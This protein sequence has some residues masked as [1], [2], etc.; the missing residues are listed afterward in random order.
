[1]KRILVIGG[2]GGFGAR[3]SRRLAA[4]G[5]HVLVAG[6]DLGK[7]TRFAATLASAEPVAADRDRDLAPVFAAC[8]PDLA[9]DAAGPFQGSHYRVPEACIA[10][11]IPYLDLADARD[12]VVGIGA[13]D[14]AAKAAGVAAIAGAS[15]MSGLSGAAVRRLAE[16]MARVD[17]V[18]MAISASNRAS[19]GPSVARAI[20]SYVGKPVRLWRG[21]DWTT[22]HGWQEMRRQAFDGL[23][24]R[25]IAIAD[26]ADHDIVP[27]A[28]PGRPATVFRAGTELGFQMRALWLGSWPVRWGWLDSLG[29]AANLLMPL[30]RATLRFGGDRSAMRVALKGVAGRLAVER[31][32]TLVAERGDGP[33]I[34]TLAAA[35]LAEDIL[36]GKVPAGARHA[37]D[38]LTLD[39]FEP[40]FAELAIRHE[41]AECAAPALYR[42]VMGADFDA[43]PTAVRRMHEIN[44]DGGAAGE[45]RVERGRGLLARLIGRVIG[46]P[47]AGAY[48]LRVAFA[49]DGG[50]EHWTRRFGPHR[51]SSR[52]SEKRG[53]AVERF[54]PLR[55]GFALSGD[56]DGLAMTMRRWSAFGIRL[57]LILAPRTIAREWQEG[58]RFHFDVAIAMP[59]AGKVIH[60]TGW[61]KPVA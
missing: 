21:R 48:P 39:R 43:L 27:A 54:G 19:G 40:L 36:A 26:V 13:L 20:L 3:L 42:R 51:F 50:V 37:W 38:A 5:H 16:G 44:G 56:A 58:D 14:A 57:P 1:M 49:E 9:V 12:F 53:L 29:R 23:G 52:L 7:A 55:F 17:Q 2:Y 10:A 6:R 60:Y 18:A 11:G 45:G 47:P 15:S 24:R 25:L 28:L 41:I 61:L 34:P 8:R 32:W 59:L 33:E 35:L 31:V 4:A 30:Y 46:F 22:G